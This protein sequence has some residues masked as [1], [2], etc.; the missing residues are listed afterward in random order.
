MAEEGRRER[1][2][3]RVALRDL[4][5]Q[6]RHGGPLT[7]QRHR[8]EDP[9][10]GGT[11]RAR[12]HRPRG[13]RGGG[14]GGSDQWGCAEA[15]PVGGPAPAAEEASSGTSA[16][17]EPPS[18]AAS[19]AS[20]A[21]APTSAACRGGERVG[22]CGGLGRGDACRGAGDAAGSRGDRCERDL[23][24]ARSGR[25]RI[26]SDA[27][28]RAQ[29]EDPLPP[30]ASARGRARPGPLADRGLGDRGTHHQAGR[31][32]GDRLRRRGGGPRGSSGSS[33]GDRARTCG[34]PGT[35]SFSGAAG[36]DGRPRPASGR[37]PR[38]RGRTHLAH[39]EADR[40]A[41]GRLAPDL[42]AR[43]DDGRGQHRPPRETAGERE[44]GASRPSTA[45]T[46]RTCRS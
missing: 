3:R 11:D 23:A 30:R 25:C 10:R 31:D 29:V 42:R 19:A 32:G 2:A 28:P 35:R 43:L 18:E 9:G 40:P 33:T 22:R 39:P 45:S 7:R 20:T 36:A 8:L 6:G 4:H 5:R 14:R 44:R 26:G 1:R 16:G 24:G 34:G 15:A 38:R 17:T 37:G 21:A 27:R 12:R 13:D 41:H 46:S